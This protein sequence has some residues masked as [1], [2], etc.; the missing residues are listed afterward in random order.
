MP[1]GYSQIVPTKSKLNYGFETE[2]EATTNNRQL[3]WPR[4]KVWEFFF[5]KCDGVHR[6]HAYDY[7][8]WRQLGNTGWSYEDVL[9]YFKKAESFQGDGDED[10]HGFEGR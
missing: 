5:N 8:L 1:S 6:G 4:G 2:P 3:Y 9:P 7:D 10:Y